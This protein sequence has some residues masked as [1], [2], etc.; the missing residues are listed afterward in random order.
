[1]YSS[2][3]WVLGRAK[4]AT[5]CITSLHVA[6]K[7]IMS[8]FNLVVSTLTA[9]PPNLVS[10]QIFQLYGMQFHLATYEKLRW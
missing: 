8:H 2:R 7:I 6:G 9:K 4:S 1:M 5:A 3:R 10:R